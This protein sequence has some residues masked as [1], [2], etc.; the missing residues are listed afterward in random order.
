MCGGSAPRYTI[1]TLDC[2]V[3][4]ANASYLAAALKVFTTLMSMG[5]T[6]IGVVFLPL[7]QSQTVEAAVVKHRQQLDNALL[8]GGLT[9]SNQF[10]L[11]Y[12]KPDSTSRDSRSLFQLCVATFHTHFPQHA[13]QQSTPVK[14][15][16]LGPAPL[17]KLSDFVGYD[18]DTRPSPSARV[19]Q[20]FGVHFH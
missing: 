14:T 1:C 11:L 10:Q 18:S 7:L 5:S 13:F 8:K 15:G 12:S 20:R 2:T 3:F 4:P 9:V 16:K 17:A 19:E 6:M